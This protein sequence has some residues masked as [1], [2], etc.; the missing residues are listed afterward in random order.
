MAEY[1]ASGHTWQVRRPWSVYCFIN[2]MY[3][4][5]CSV[6]S[7]FIASKFGVGMKNLVLTLPR[8]V[9][10]LDARRSARRRAGSHSSKGGTPQP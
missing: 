7:E 6:V 8:E 1:H 2:V 9:L 4:R 5:S 10:E 3:R